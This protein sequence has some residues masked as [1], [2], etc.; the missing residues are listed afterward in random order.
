MVVEDATK[1]Q[2]FS[3]N[4]LVLGEPMIRFYAGV[5]IYIDHQAIGTLCAIDRRPRVL[6]SPQRQLLVELAEMARDEVEIRQAAFEATRT[7]ELLRLAEEV[8]SVGH[9]LVYAPSNRVHWSANAYRLHGY[10]PGVDPEPTIERFV[11]AYV[12]ND[13]ERLLGALDGALD[14]GL[15]FDLELTLAREG[16]PKVRVM[17]GVQEGPEHPSST[18]AVFG[19]LR[20]LV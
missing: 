7:T 20:E 3:E 5:P 15:G 8:A 19:V 16:R 2:R 14:D 4:P 10:D 9:F 12:P 18:L 11:S 6:S 1:D 13:G 17:G